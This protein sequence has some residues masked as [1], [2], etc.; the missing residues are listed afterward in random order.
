ML[1]LPRS[2]AAVAALAAG[3][4]TRYAVSCVR[5]REMADSWWR[6]DATDGRAL[7]IVRGPSE[8]SEKEK[9]AAGAL[10]EPDSHL[11]EVLLPGGDFAGL[12]K[13]LPRPQ[14]GGKPGRLGLLLGRPEVV[15]LAGPSVVRLAPGD[16]RFPDTDA[17]L[18]GAPAP[19]SICVNPNLL[20]AL[21][22]AAAA[23]AGDG[24][25]VELLLWRPHQPMGVTSR[26]ENGLTFDGILMP[27]T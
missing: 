25:R 8:P 1:F 4:D 22:R 14:R 17:V 15:A 18:P 9:E 10:P 6:L 16:G 12:F 13:A 19:A 3:Q 24:Q 21:L 20:I 23:V 7:A 11:L 2:A 27:L 5:L 26:G